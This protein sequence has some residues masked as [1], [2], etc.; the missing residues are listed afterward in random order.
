MRKRG[1]PRD[2]FTA[3]G[4]IERFL[5]P[6]LFWAAMIF[7]CFGTAGSLPCLAQDETRWLVGR[8]FQQRL[9]SVT[10][11]TWSE[12]PIREGIAGLSRAQRIGIWLDR[13]I[14]PGY[15]PEFASHGTTLDVLLRRLAAKLNGGVGY[16]ESVVYLGP[17]ATA[18]KLPT[19]V[20]L[21]MDE[22][23]AL[24]ESVRSR[25]LQ[26]RVTRWDMLAEPRAIIDQL[27][28]ASRISV[29]GADQV[30][31]DLWPA[32]ELP[33][34]TL[35]ERLSLVLSG[36]DLTFEIAPDGS[37][38]RIL[39][40][41][42]QA[43][44]IR[45]YAVRG[46]VDQIVA[47]L[48]GSFPEAGVRR[49]GAEIQ[50]AG[51]YEDHRAIER[52]LRGEKVQRTA[53][54]GADT[55]YSLR[56]ENQPVGGLVTSLSRQLELELVVDPRVNSLLLQRIKFQVSEVT[57]E[58]LLTKALRDTGIQYQLQGKKLLLSPSE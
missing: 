36:F 50:V 47:K 45:T 33:P 9:D 52:V 12:N 27:A 23:K 29:L 31:H 41:P 3:S 43:V 24:P 15:R 20:A 26:T 48:A 44:L 49:A 7:G 58:E 4:E 2:Q 28:T 39:P 22:A 56:F 21:R 14:D 8:E 51:S 13:R 38:V 17:T 1:M 5:S 19:L 54:A 30:P 40:M 42:E 11:I 6:S 18:R 10:G 25:F 53:V 55:R 16:L 35:V 37:A 57:L 32:I 34:L 46:N